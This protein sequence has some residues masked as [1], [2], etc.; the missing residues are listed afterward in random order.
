[1]T[2]FFLQL[3]LSAAERVSAL[4]ARSKASAVART[5]AVAATAME[6]GCTVGAA[7]A[8]ARMSHTRR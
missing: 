4:S 8:H 3:A 5:A 7:A 6:T 2:G 1:M